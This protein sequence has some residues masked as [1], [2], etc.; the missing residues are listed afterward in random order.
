MFKL[1]NNK[2]T[3]CRAWSWYA[4]LHH[5]M[6]YQWP[7]EV[8][9]GTE[10]GIEDVQTSPKKVMICTWSVKVE[11]LLNTRIHRS[12]VSVIGFLEMLLDCSAVLI[13]LLLLKLL[14]CFF[15]S[16][17]QKSQSKGHNSWINCLWQFEDG[18]YV[19]MNIILKSTFIYCELRVMKLG[20]IV[21]RVDITL[22][23]GFTS[24][25]RINW[26]TAG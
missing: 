14:S 22:S 16:H 8:G 1:L 19:Y 17:G 2:L 20:P 24:I 23:I 12:P 15:K 4:F 10:G 21:R 13:L 7:L 6:F 5:P 26:F 9:F 11:S 3:L 25:Q 18:N